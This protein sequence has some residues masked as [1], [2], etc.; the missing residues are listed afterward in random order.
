MAARRNKYSRLL[1][2][3]KH[4]LPLFWTSISPTSHTL[5]LCCI[6]IICPVIGIGMF[7][8][9]MVYFII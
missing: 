5:L 8:L 7:R 9:L 1:E 4:L 2:Q 3:R 6:I